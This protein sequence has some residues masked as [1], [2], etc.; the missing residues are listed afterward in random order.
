METITLNNKNIH[1]INNKSELNFKFLAPIYRN[2]VQIVL[3]FINNNDL[4]LDLGCGKGVYHR[5]FKK[6]IGI[7][8]ELSDLKKLKSSNHIVIL[9]DAGHLPIKENSIQNI[10]CINTLE[11]VSDL[12]KTYKEIFRI[13]KHNGKLILVVDNFDYPLIFDPINFLICRL[14]LKPISY[15]AWNWKQTR[16]FKKDQLVNDLKNTGFSIKKSEFFSHYLICIFNY[17]ECAFYNSFLSSE[18]KNSYMLNSKNIKTK[19]ENKNIP[20]LIF[21]CLNFISKIICGLDNLI[22]KNSNG[23]NILIIAKKGK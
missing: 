22:F 15:G 23:A 18:Y 11:Y 4:I 20:K 6:S 5:F 10:I 13:L 3:N 7:D 21:L 2:K 8:K 17:F 12:K 9:A 16:R 19:N 14:G 1:K